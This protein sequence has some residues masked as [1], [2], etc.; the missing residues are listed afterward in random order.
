MVNIFPY[1]EK[2]ICVFYTMPNQRNK[3]KTQKKVKGGKL[4]C[5]TSPFNYFIKCKDGEVEAER[6]REAALANEAAAKKDT[7]MRV[8]QL[9]AEQKAFDEQKKS[10]ITALKN[11]PTAP[12][13]RWGVFGGR[14]KNKSQK[15]KH[16]KK[17]AK[18]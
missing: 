7:E 12:T 4:W 16:S 18:K 17:S 1:L 9:E 2:N 14:R 6:V 10:Q 3:R 13:K 8:K 15:R 5:E 11:T